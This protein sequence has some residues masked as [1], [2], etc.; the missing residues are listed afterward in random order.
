[1]A[2]WMVHCR[3]ADRFIDD[4]DG[5]IEPAE[6][7][8]G[9]VAPDCGYGVKDS[10]GQFDPPPYVTHWSKSGNK[11][12]CRYKDFGKKYLR[13]RRNN[14]GYSFY[15]GYYV[16]LMTDIMWSSE[17]YIRS[18][19]KYAEEFERDRNFLKVIKHDWNDLDL[20]YHRDNPDMT[21]YKIL[22]TVE[23]VRDY[24]PYYEHGQLTAQIRQ[25]ADYYHSG[26]GDNLDREYKYITE[27]RVS[28]FV[29][30]AVDII[31]NDLEKKELV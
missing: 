2:T 22:D 3:I 27:E 4:F 11:T 26:E 12:D 29:E 1:M 15:L 23:K 21:S 9:S 7:V 31:K 8:I 20:K 10:A 18:R 6:F 16:H 13:G 25:I 17:M 5:R 19:T 14:D 30:A 24:L 28:E